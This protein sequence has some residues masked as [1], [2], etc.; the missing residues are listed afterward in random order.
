MAETGHVRV[1]EAVV[2]APQTI[3]QLF[4]DAVD[5]FGTKR[6]ALR[7]KADGTWHDITHQEFARRVKHIGLGLRELG[8]EPGD[9]V[10][11]LATNRPEWAIADLGSLT[12]GCTDVSV[13]PSL[14]PHQV[15]YILQDSGSSAVFV[16]DMGQLDKVLQ[17]R[18]EVSSLKHVIAFEHDGAAP[19]L[20]FHELALMGE[21]AEKKYA[22]YHDD[23]LAIPPDAVAT[24]IYTSGT[25]GDP[26]GVMLTH[27]NLTRNV[28]AALEVLPVSANDVCLSVLPL[29]H[30]FERNAGFYVMIGAGAT[31]AYAEDLN[32][33][34]PNL[35]EIK[36]TVML[37][38]PRLY[39][40]MY[41]R[42]LERALSGGA[43]K[44][45]IFLWARRTA[46]RWANR[47]LAKEPIPA[48]LAFA[49]RIADRLVFSKLKAQTGGRMRFFVSGAAPLLPEIAKFFYAAGLPILEGYG[50]T[51]TAPIISVNP[52]EAP[53]VGTVGIILPGID[54]RIADDGEI[55][56]R[57]PNVM[58]G[59][60]H[61]S[62]KTREVIDE[63]GWFHTG[64]IGEVDDAGYLRITDRKKD[65]IVTAG[66]KNIAP[67]PIE[68]RVKVST[69]VANA[70]MIGDKR[71]FPIILVVP[72][73]D[74]LKNWAKERSLASDDPSQLLELPD[75][76]AKIEREV[77]VTLRDLAGYQ[78]PKKIVIID[79]DFTEENGALTPSLKVKRHVIEER[80]RDRIEACYE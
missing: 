67:Q 32:S 29:S 49:Y 9:R 62:E 58:Q 37:A 59:Y 80:Y 71:K 51:E 42:V 38:V 54:H 19:A 68:N 15:R 21:A 63:D 28:Q 65:I 76:T 46:D 78:M 27:G 61:K 7:Y 18:D 47:R 23:A 25:T 75:V 8:I 5:R 4:F 66:G 70:V 77:M 11:I 36:P 74:A 44:K 41:A 22:T 39:E 3:P 20:T 64:D 13:Y 48:P 69:F 1:S 24:I 50:L 72:E 2:T 53:R 6:A 52:L 14:M 45:R 73:R 57:G 40:K 17:I 33:V 31:I 12:V 79:E 56:V 43:V 35:K 10:A 16:E 55:L 30:A 34:G 60:Y 26:K